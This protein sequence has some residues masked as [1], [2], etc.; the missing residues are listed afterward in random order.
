MYGATTRTTSGIISLEGIGPRLNSVVVI[1]REAFVEFRRLSQV[2]T[3]PSLHKGLFSSF[4]PPG[5]VATRHMPPYANHH[6]SLM[7]GVSYYP[8]TS[9]G[10]QWNPQ[11][12]AYHH[13]PTAAPIAPPALPS[14]PPLLPLALRSRNHARVTTPT[15]DQRVAPQVAPQYYPITPLPFNLPARPPSTPQQPITFAPNVSAESYRPKK[16]GTPKPIV[17]NGTSKGSA[18]PA[19]TPSGGI[20]SFAT[21]FRWA[22]TIDFSG[23]TSSSPKCGGAASTTSSRCPAWRCLCLAKAA[24]S[25][26]KRSDGER[27]AVRYP[28]CIQRHSYTCSSSSCCAITVL[29]RIPS[30]VS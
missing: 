11:Q 3:S 7:P 21:T 22:N 5:H 29:S 13:T 9:V 26:L 14:K 28:G 2:H 20:K 10:Y 18:S 17:T 24:A 12:A 1:V 15:Y 23:G 8:A 4:P 19:P 16:G 6:P 30:L 27:G 25:A